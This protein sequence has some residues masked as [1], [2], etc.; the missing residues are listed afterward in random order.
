MRTN[1]SPILLG[2]RSGIVS[3]PTNEAF[4]ALLNSR[5]VRAVGLRVGLSKAALA[6]E[7]RLK[8]N[9]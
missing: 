4:L 2:R 6:E 9:G 8:L 1:G 7:V 5:E 3:V